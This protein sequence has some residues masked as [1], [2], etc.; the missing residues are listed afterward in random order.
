M[1]ASQSG[2]ASRDSWSEWL[3]RRRFGDDE[4]E[5]RTTLSFLYPVRDRVLDHAGIG[6]G[7]TLLD[8]GAGDGLVAFGALDRI[9]PT[10]RVVFSDV[11]RDLL[12]HAQGLAEES[13]VADRCR[14]V[15]ASADDLS[16]VASS[17]VDAVT[18]RSVLIYLPRDR[19]RK[20]L[21]EFARVLRPGG[22]VSLYEPVSSF[23]Y[24]EVPGRFWGY[25]VAGVRDLAVK[26]AAIFHRRQ[27]PGSDTLMDFDAR[28][29]FRFAVEAGFGELH[30]R[31]EVDRVPPPPRIWHT[32]AATAF[33]PR[34]PTLTEAME[35]ALTP[36]E[37]EVFVAH[38]RPLVEAGTGLFTL[39][40]ACL[41]GTV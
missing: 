38:L 31:L 7:S 5:L 17:S 41:W 10:G 35:E 8:V 30:L 33:N 6:D 22:R 40:I 36:E 13:G 34:M 3:L 11:S 26:V 18:T 27:P 4:D 16:A 29:L 32:L 1:A 37:A 12:E 23:D 2:G 21:A 25:D 9:G 14:F 20:A 28:D 19:K 15:E 39:P 24:P